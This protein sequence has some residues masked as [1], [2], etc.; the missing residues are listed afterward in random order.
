MPNSHLSLSDPSAPHSPASHEAA[1]EPMGGYGTESTV[2]RG[3]QVHHSEAGMCDMTFVTC[4]PQ[5]HHV[6]LSGGGKLGRG[7]KNVGRMILGMREF[8]ELV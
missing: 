7:Y 1:S 3:V 2:M 4:L 8:R 5:P 6:V